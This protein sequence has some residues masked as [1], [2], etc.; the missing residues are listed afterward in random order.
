[1]ELFRPVIFSAEAV[2]DIEPVY[3]HYSNWSF[4]CQ[5]EMENGRIDLPM[6]FFLAISSADDVFLC[7]M[8]K[9]GILNGGTCMLSVL[10]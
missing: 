10:Y 1:M 2:I 9:F 6:E 5:E 4:N 3:K 8:R 7:S